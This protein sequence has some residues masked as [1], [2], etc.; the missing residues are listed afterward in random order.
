MGSEAHATAV[1]CAV[2]KCSSESPPPLHASAPL[3]GDVMPAH[4]GRAACDLCAVLNSPMCVHLQLSGLADISKHAGACAAAGYSTSCA[5][6]CP[7][8]ACAGLRHCAGLSR[9]SPRA[10]SRGSTRIAMSMGA[11][12]CVSSGL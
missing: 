12:P 9:K 3:V 4:T 5:S 10:C 8:S 7:G 11:L 6:L 2:S 1:M